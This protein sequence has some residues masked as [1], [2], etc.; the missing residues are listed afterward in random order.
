MID[1]CFSNLINLFR[2]AAQNFKYHAKLKTIIKRN[3]GIIVKQVT[4]YV[5]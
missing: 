3:V 1:D 5:L 2:F 4:Y